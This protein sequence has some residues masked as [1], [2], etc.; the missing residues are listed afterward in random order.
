MVFFQNSDI[1]DYYQSVSFRIIL[2]TV[3]SCPR[4]TQLTRGNNRLC[5]RYSRLRKETLSFT[6]VTK[7]LV[8][9]S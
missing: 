5:N 9:P 8:A 3:L 2:L 6:L 1:N 7:I 4:N